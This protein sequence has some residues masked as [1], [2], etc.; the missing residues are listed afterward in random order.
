MSVFETTVYLSE[1]LHLFKDRLFLFLFPTSV[2][3]F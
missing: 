3:K 2:E 1:L